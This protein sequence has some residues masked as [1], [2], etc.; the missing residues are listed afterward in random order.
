MLTCTVRAHIRASCVPYAPKAQGSL[1][2]GGTT[3]VFTPYTSLGLLWHPRRSR[4][5]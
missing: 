1:P 2:R 5:G 4:S 3:A